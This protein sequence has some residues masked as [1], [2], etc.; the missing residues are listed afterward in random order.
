MLEYLMIK[1]NQSGKPDDTLLA[2]TLDH[3]YYGEI[4]ASEFITGDVLAAD[5][6]L[7]SGVAQYSEAGWL[8]FAHE[9][10]TLYVAKRP[11]RRSI[12]WNQINAIGA[13]FGTKTVSINGQNF[14]VRLLRGRGDGL[15]TLVS[16]FDVEASHNSEWNRLLYHVS[17]KPFATIENDLSSEGI[18]E[19]DWAEY[20]EAEL[21]MHDDFGAGS[22]SWCQESAGAYRIVRGYLGVSWLEYG[23]SSSTAAYVGW[24]PCLELIP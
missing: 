19:G 1:Q 13:V 10:K 17:G 20:S 2:G 12:S 24:R 21:L 8:K 14:K 11:F 22:Y 16:G 15:S 3:G 6:G 23:A 9:G 5:I 4:D 18:S 7:V